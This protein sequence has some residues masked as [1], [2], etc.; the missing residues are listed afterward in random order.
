MAQVV[1]NLPTMHETQVQSLGQED[2]LEK[3]R[4]TAGGS[5]VSTPV[6]LPGE[7]CGERSLVGNSPWS[8]K[9]LD[10]TEQLTPYRKSIKI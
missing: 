7:F 6:L 9:E 8:H 5:E 10:M 1:H 4:A 2:L 3:G